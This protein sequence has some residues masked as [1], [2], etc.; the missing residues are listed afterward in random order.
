M[1]KVFIRLTKVFQ[2]LIKLSQA[3]DI[4]SKADLV[5]YPEVQ[6]YLGYLTVLFLHDSKDYTKALA[7][8]SDLVKE[9][10]RKN[11]R[12]CDQI[13]SRMYFYYSRINELAG[14]VNEIHPFLMA[15]HRTAVLRQDTEC[16][17]I[18]ILIRLRFSTCCCVTIWI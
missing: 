5:E 4:E 9:V 18:L 6:F 13:A 1:L 11:R 12:T 8:C 17:V 2:K 7:L 3:M 14:K 15:A 16:Q 10:Q